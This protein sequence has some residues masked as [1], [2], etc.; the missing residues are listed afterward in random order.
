MAIGTLLGSSLLEIY[1]YIYI[2][3]QRFFSFLSIYMASK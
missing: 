3:K 1:I 2:Y